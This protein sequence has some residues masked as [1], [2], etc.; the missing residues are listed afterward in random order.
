MGRVITGFSAMASLPM[1]TNINEQQIAE[2][3]ADSL[4]IAVSLTV[5]TGLFM[6]RRHDGAMVDR[7]E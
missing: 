7:S 5:A 3:R 1:V 4:I 2:A 6:V